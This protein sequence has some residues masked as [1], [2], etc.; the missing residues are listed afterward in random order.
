MERRR[1]LVAAADPHAASVLRFV[2]GLSGGEVEVVRAIDEA[3]NWMRSRPAYDLAVI[4]GSAPLPP[5]VILAELEKACR[6]LSVLWVRRDPAEGVPE[7]LRRLGAVPCPPEQIALRAKELI[8][9]NKGKEEPDG[10]R[11]AE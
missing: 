9:N 10:G 2:L 7:P 1:I 3:V 4:D 11:E 8:R 6:G 5:P